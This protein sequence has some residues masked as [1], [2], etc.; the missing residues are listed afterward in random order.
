MAYLTAVESLPAELRSTLKS[1][2]LAWLIPGVATVC[3]Y[4]LVWRSET[5]PTG[6][7][8]VHAVGYGFWAPLVSMMILGLVQAWALGMLIPS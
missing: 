4:L 5:M 1:M 6:R 2:P 3:L 7:K 8:Y